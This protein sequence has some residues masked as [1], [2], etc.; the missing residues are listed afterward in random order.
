MRDILECVGICASRTVTEPHPGI[1]MY[2]PRYVIPIVL[3]RSSMVY[4]SRAIAPTLLLR[5]YK[6]SGQLPAKH[7]QEKQ[8]SMHLNIYYHLLVLRNLSYNK[9]QDKPNFD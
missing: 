3:M 1:I 6:A 7:I 4:S 5:R 2:Q 8:A 9:Y